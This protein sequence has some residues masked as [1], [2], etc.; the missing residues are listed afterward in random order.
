MGM[1]PPLMIMPRPL[2]GMPRPLTGM[3]RPLTGMPRPLQPGS[4][5]IHIVLH[6]LIVQNTGEAQGNVIGN[7]FE[8]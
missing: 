7:R 8:I 5:H 4:R 6:G 3:P 2:M 1:P